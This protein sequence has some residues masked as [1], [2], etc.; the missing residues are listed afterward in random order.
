G[1]CQSLYLQHELLKRDFWGENKIDLIVTSPYKRAIL[2][3]LAISRPKD[4]A[5]SCNF[6]VGQLT[7]SPGLILATQRYALSKVGVRFPVAEVLKWPIS[8]IVDDKKFDLLGLTKHQK[9]PLIVNPLVSEIRRNNGDIGSKPA[10]L[11]ETFSKIRFNRL[12]ENW[13]RDKKQKN[14]K[15]SVTE[16]NERTKNFVDWI[17][18]RKEKNILIV[19][20]SLFIKALTG[21]RKLRNCEILCANINKF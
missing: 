12:K 9:I 2:T 5:V 18:T 13:W 6:P 15:E 8:D 1:I 20:H 4:F 10:K 16:V 7:K 21:S 3:A 14:F 19:T 11:R 17:L